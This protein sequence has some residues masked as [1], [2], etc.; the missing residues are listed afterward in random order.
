MQ[1]RICNRPHLVPLLWA[2]AAALTAGAVLADDGEQLAV[3][4]QQPRGDGG[5]AATFS[6][7]HLPRLRAAARELGV[8]VRVIDAGSGAPPE[9]RLT[10]LIVYQ[11]HRGRSIFQARYADP[12]KLRHFVRT[13]RAVPPAGTSQSR[14]NIAALADGRSLTAAPIKVTELAGHPPPGHEPA[15][16]RARAEA[17]A[18]AGLSRFGMRQEVEIGPSNRLFYM[19][20]YPHLS[21][22]GELSVSLGLFSQFN[23]IEPVYRRFEAPI[24]GPWEEAERVFAEAAAVLEAEVLRQIAASEIG[25]AFQA[26]PTSVPEVSWEAL[27]LALPPPPAGAAS[28]PVAD[29]ELPRRWRIE[30]AADGEPRLVFR[31]PAPLERYSGE[32]REL[33]GVLELTDPSSFAG[34]AGWI[35]AA[36]ASVT[37]GEPTLDRAIHEKMIHAHE[38]PSARFDLERVDDGAP[39]LAFG[40]PSPIV[41]HGR[42][43]LMGLSIPVEARGELEPVIGAD[44]APR[45]R[46]RAT[47]RIRLSRPF[48]IAGPDG[49]TPA[50]DTLVF[51]LSFLM[52]EARDDS[53]L[54][55]GP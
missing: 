55:P 8:P 46:V 35:E 49:P 36:T 31:F 5:A 23:C 14:R 21:A 47:Y 52:Q 25:D 9:V 53:G 37:M 4:V 32:V 6:S 22:A 13:S 17:A 12:G 1:S 50:N 44:G 54:H 34:A 2:V 20:F 19:D 29:I 42:F 10:P 11:S 51:H 30:P 45:L 26:V 38:F 27:G 15:A 16:F 3:F 7:E 40:R 43:T 48:E 39:P 24:T 41:A 28:T 18:A 33:N